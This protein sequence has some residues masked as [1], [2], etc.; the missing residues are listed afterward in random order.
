MK[1]SRKVKSF[2]LLNSSAQLLFLEALFFLGWARIIKCFP[3]A[4]VTPLLGEKMGETPYFNTRQNLE[5][6][7]KVSQA[8]A[9]MGH[10]TFWE[11]KCLVM[12]L[13]GMKML[14]RRKIESTLYL[15]IS[16]D[17]NGKMIAHAWL[18]SGTF[19]VSGK[20]GMGRFTIV[21]KFAKRIVDR[22]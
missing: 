8:I 16:K 19:Y 5:M 11:C 21:G 20:E 1:F 15:G 18:R 12:A 7:E 14:E 10:H 9:K 6:A 2:L 4:K 13:A 3:F 22:R 17:E